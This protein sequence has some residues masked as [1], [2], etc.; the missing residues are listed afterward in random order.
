MRKAI[1]TEVWSGKSM[2]RTSNLVSLK[3]ILEAETVDQ[4]LDSFES[5]IRVANDVEQENGCQ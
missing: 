1:N 4:G 5:Y 2:T 3:E